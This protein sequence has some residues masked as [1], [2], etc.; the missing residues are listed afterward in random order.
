MRTEIVTAQRKKKRQTQ[1]ERF[2]QR[3]SGSL[4]GYTHR[5]RA[6]YIQRR[7]RH[8]AYADDLRFWKSIAAQHKRLVRHHGSSAVSR[9]QARARAAASRIRCGYRS[10]QIVVA[11]L[12]GG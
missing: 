12:R 2:A 6:Y 10:E 11:G 7:C 3:P 1:R 8:L 9:A 5:T 4:Q